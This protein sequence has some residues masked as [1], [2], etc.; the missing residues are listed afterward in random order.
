MKYSAMVAALL[1]AVP[2]WAQ[3]EEKIDCKN[4]VVQ[5]EMNVCS[6][7]D[8]QA[9]D[10]KLN[11][12]YKKVLAASENE[13]AAANLKA[14]QRAW[15]AFRDAECIFEANPEE[16]GTIRPL[17]ENMCLTKLTNARTEQ[18]GDALK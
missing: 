17:L 18:L 4:A 10:G 1:F 3:D 8:Y 11:R 9:A 12:I 5:Y 6:Y 7:R 14:A 2:A 16:G 13:A 15:I